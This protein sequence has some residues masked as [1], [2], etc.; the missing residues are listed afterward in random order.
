[1][2][3]PLIWFG[4]K[5]MMVPKL[6]KLLP[7][8]QYYVEVFGGGASL[9]FAKEPAPAEVYNDVD[10][11]LYNFFSVLKDKKSFENFYKLATL[12]PYS[13]LEFNYA[14]LQYEREEDPVKRAYYFFVTVRQSFGGTLSSFGFDVLAS[15]GKNYKR[16]NSWLSLLEL[17][18]EMHARLM[19]V[20]VEGRDWRYI[21]GEY[22]TPDYFA[23]LDPPYV[24]STRRSRRYKH[25][26]TDA[27][28]KEMVEIMLEYPGMIMLSGYDSELYA[29]LREAGW[30]KQRYET[31]CHITGKTRGNI[32]SREERKREEC[33]WRNPRCMEAI[34]SVKGEV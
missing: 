13:R 17:L 33:V 21:L 14:K 27:D 1:M 23:Y 9:L 29:P 26:L 22:N 10:E 30:D 6:V 3:S 20:Q 12:T 15:A 32:K 5:G 2:R 16:V 8:H 18:P 19:R 28:H 24:M 25:E 34:R 11:S 31:V 7:P 4:G